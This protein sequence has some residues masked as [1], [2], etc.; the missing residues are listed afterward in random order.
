M[1]FYL[2]L[3]LFRSVNLKYKNP[4]SKQSIYASYVR[5]CAD[6]VNERNSNQILTFAQIDSGEFGNWSY[7]REALANC[8]Y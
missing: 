7:F 8:G 3:T 4:M 1:G 6:N 2:C 5:F